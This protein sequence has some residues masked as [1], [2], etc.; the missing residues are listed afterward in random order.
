MAEGGEKVEAPPGLDIQYTT[1]T[2]GSRHDA[3]MNQSLLDRLKVLLP[4][5][6]LSASPQTKGPGQPDIM[7]QIINFLDGFSFDDDKVTSQG[8]VTNGGDRLLK[9]FKLL[10]KLYV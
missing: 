6:L 5:L 1:T 7:N 10:I 4:K 8:S 2:T 3:S 9:C